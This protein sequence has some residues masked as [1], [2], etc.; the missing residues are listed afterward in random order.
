MVNWRTE[1]KSIWMDRAFQEGGYNSHEDKQKETEHQNP[2][3]RH[4]IFLFIP[5]KN[6]YTSNLLVI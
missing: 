4:S 3:L 2:T 1:R 5:N 6:D